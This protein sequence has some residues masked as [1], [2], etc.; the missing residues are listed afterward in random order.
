MATQERHPFTPQQR[1]NQAFSPWMNPDYG[2]PYPYPADAG[3]V[4]LYNALRAKTGNTPQN[5]NVPPPS[6]GGHGLASALRGPPSAADGLFGVPP[7]QLQ[8]MAGDVI[9]PS[10]G[11]FLPVDPA[12]PWVAQQRFENTGIQPSGQKILPPNPPSNVITISPR[13]IDRYLR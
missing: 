13:P 5:P 1:I 10:L 9:Y 12:A 4:Q 2:G 7:Q 8:R 6:Q 11:R 3:I